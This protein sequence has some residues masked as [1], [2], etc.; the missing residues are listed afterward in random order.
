VNR[1]ARIAE[2]VARTAGGDILVEPFLK[3]ARIT[4]M[5]VTTGQTSLKDFVTELAVA[6]SEVNREAMKVIEWLKIVG[7]RGVKRNIGITPKEGMVGC[8]VEFSRNLTLDDNEELPLYS[9]W[10]K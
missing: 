2:K 10:S 8:V 1:E 6:E 5:G 9:T 7:I 3:Y 4:R